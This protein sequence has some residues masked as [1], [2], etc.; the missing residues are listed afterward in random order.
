MTFD[1]V[2]LREVVEIDSKQVS[3]SNIK[4]GSVYVGLEHISRGGTLNQETVVSAGDLKSSKFAFDERHVLFGKL[5]PNLGKIALPSVSGICSTDI[6][7]LRPK[8]GLDRVWLALWLQT[9]QI[10]ELA[11]S[12]ATG[13]NLPRIS[14][15]VLGEFSIPLPSIEEQN[16][17]S[18]ILFDALEIRKVILKKLS[19]LED[20]ERSIYE[21]LVSGVSSSKFPE[22]PLIEICETI[23]DGTHSSPVRTHAG[24]PVLSAQNVKNGI[25]SSKTDR[26]TNAEELAA[27]QKRVLPRE[28]DV[29]LTIVGT[30]GRSAVLESN[31]DF[32]LQRSVAILRPR[33]GLV[34]SLFLNSSFASQEF[35]NQLMRATNTS[36]QAGV[37]L[38][39]LNKLTITLPPIEVQKVFENR[40]KTTI[41]AKQLL[42]NHLEV[43]NEFYAALQER[44][45]RGEL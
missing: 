11:A 35:Q 43:W 39:K 41:S 14:S 16:R 6:L 1:T 5:R 40:I 21:E 8:N 22:V 7:P 33:L 27:F 45:F 15:K 9:P 34:N 4:S 31:F 23:T 25:F 37:Y 44:A 26:F 28:G 30:V 24:V 10:V 13:A 19:L 29:L 17:L 42:L 2:L 18:G 38:A 3:S 20:L 36:T 32:V 12:R